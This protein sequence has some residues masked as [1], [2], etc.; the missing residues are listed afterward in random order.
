ML[1]NFSDEKTQNN[2]YS[3]AFSFSQLTF[4]GYD[5]PMFNS[6]ANQYYYIGPC[7]LR[8]TFLYLHHG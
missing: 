4:V 3:L 7:K 6:D 5:K 1:G 8:M 2:G